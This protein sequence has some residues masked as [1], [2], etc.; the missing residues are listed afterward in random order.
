[1]SP[2]VTEI[3]PKVNHHGPLIITFDK[4]P[5]ICTH[6][7]VL[8]TLSKQLG[9]FVRNLNCV[10]KT[11][12]EKISLRAGGVSMKLK[13]VVQMIQREYKI[14]KLRWVPVINNIESIKKVSSSKASTSQH[15]QSSA[16]DPP[17]NEIP[18]KLSLEEAEECMRAAVRIYSA[19]NIREGQQS[20]GILLKRNTGG[21][22]AVE[23]FVLGECQGKIDRERKNIAAHCDATEAR[24]EEVAEDERR[25]W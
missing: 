13:S 25:N 1:M 12:V 16:K 8:E 18:V 22:T 10:H 3:Q 14:D 2:F 15:V 9:E 4:D 17:G 20:E 21:L 11:H 24:L 19:R 6:E 5:R 7:E 23:T